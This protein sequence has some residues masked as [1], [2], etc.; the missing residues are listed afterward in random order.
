MASYVIPVE[1]EHV[2][3]NALVAYHGRYINA[4]RRKNQEEGDKD[5]D[6][7]NNN[8]SISWSHHRHWPI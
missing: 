7:N 2:P 8:D 4:T 5:V 3:L 1:T 6:N